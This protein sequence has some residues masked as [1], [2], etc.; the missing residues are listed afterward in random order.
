M[1]GLLPSMS[2]LRNVYKHTWRNLLPM[3]TALHAE[4]DRELPR[5]VLAPTNEELVSMIG[6]L[7]GHLAAAE[8]LVAAERLAA[9]EQLGAEGRRVGPDRRARRG[10]RAGVGR[11]AGAEHPPLHTHFE[12]HVD[13]VLEATV[14]AVEGPGIVDGVS[15]GLP[16]VS[17]PCK[18]SAMGLGLSLTVAPCIH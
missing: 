4:M 14:P 10:R 8:R 5:L 13:R 11:R 1:L 15:P 3:E 7:E 18:T 17:P 9:A 12:I 2:T 6:K 16:F